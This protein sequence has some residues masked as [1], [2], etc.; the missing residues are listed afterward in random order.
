MAFIASECHKSPDSRLRKHHMA[1]VF[2]D[3]GVGS[4]SS[5]WMDSLGSPSPSLM[6]FLI[7]LI[8]SGKL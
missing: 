5:G 7:P 2:V 4:F 1:S 6:A 8:A 3:E